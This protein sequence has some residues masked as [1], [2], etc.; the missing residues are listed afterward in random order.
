MSPG[1]LIMTEQWTRVP[2]ASGDEPP[3]EAAATLALRCSP[4]ERG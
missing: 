4:R 1:A 2:R 3:D